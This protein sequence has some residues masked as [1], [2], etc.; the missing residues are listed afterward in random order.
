LDWAN[1]AKFPL[2]IYGACLSLFEKELN[3]HDRYLPSQ[4]AQTGNTFMFYPPDACFSGWRSPLAGILH[5]L[6]RRRC[7]A[8]MATGIVQKLSYQKHI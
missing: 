8:A 3:Y 2:E 1:A 5:R 7:C 4:H 6:S